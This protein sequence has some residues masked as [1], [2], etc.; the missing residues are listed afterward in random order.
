MAAG[1]D[2]TYTYNVTNTGDVFLTN[3]I[4][5][6]NVYGSIGSTPS[7]LAPGASATLNKTATV[8]A[9]VTNTGTVTCNHQLG[10]VSGNDSATVRVIHPA[11]DVVKT[12]EPATQQE[13]GTI[14]W[15][16]R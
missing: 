10:H 5:T 9:N 8:S 13:P 11:I 12:C 4:V 3:C 2:V 16:V 14:N 6:D 1:T 15:K 7:P